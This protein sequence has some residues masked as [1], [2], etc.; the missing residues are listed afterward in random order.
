LKTIGK[1]PY[2]ILKYGKKNKVRK[3]SVKDAQKKKGL[4]PLS[5]QNKAKSEIKE[6]WRD[7]RG[8]SWYV[9]QLFFYI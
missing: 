8:K 5:G 7:Q 1:S 4:W 9:N 2:G 6:T 3:L